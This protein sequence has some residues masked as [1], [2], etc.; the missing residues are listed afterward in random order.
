TNNIDTIIFNVMAVDTG[1]VS[2]S[3]RYAQADTGKTGLIEVDGQTLF[4]NFAYPKVYDEWDVWDRV[5]FNIYFSEGP[6]TIKLINNDQDPYGPRIDYLS[7]CN[8]N[9]VPEPVIAKGNNQFEQNFDNWVRLYNWGTGVSNISID[10]SFA[11]CGYKD[12][13]IGN[14]GGYQQLITTIDNLLIGDTVCLHF[15]AAGGMA[16]AWVGPSSS[17]VFEGTYHFVNVMW[18]QG[19]YVH[20]SIEFVATEPSMII[21]FDIFPNTELYLDNFSFDGYGCEPGPE[22]Y[23]TGISCYGETDASITVNCTGGAYPLSY[24][25]NTGDTVETILNLG[26]GQYTVSATDKNG[27][28]NSISYDIVEP[29]EIY[30]IS[31][32]SHETTVGAGDGEINVSVFGGISPYTYLWSTGDTVKNL[33]NV[34]GGF[35]T[36]SISDSHAC[37]LDSTFEV[38][39]VSLLPTPGWS[40]QITAVSHIFLFQPTAQLEID[41][42]PLTTGDYV[43]AF[44]D[45]LGTYA[46]AGYM[47]WLNSVNSVTVFGDDAFTSWPD[48]F[49]D[50][51][52]INWKVWRSSDSVL[53]NASATYVTNAPNIPD[54][55]YFAPNGLS[56]I[57]SMS[58]ACSTQTQSIVL[59]QGWDMYSSYLDIINPEISLVFDSILN[60]LILIKN[61]YGNVY[62]PAFNYN[63]I[64]DMITGQGYHINMLQTD[65][66]YISGNTIDPLQTTLSLPSGWSLVGYLHTTPANIVLML[67][68]IVSDLVIAKDGSGNVYWPLFNINTIGNMIPGK[69]YQLKLSASVSFSYPAITT[70]NSKTLLNRIEPVHFQKLKSG[71][72]N[73]TLGIPINTWQH[74]PKT[75]DEIGVFSQSGL[76]VGSSVFSGGNL[77][78]AIW[79]DD[80]Y[81]ENIAGLQKGEKFIL[82]IWHRDNGKEEIID[83]ENWSEGDDIYTAD[84]IAIVG[85]LFYSSVTGENIVLYQNMP[86]PFTNQT[87]FSFYLPA[88]T[89]VEFSI[90]NLL[91]EKIDLVFSGT[92]EAGLHR[93]KYQTKNLSAGSYYYHLKTTGFSSTKKMVV[94]KGGNK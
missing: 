82:K 16:N 37:L 52:A 92:K 33:L 20:D 10:S 45:S 63:G 43:G 61:T 42:V 69:G 62:W 59:Q 64:G 84:K 14:A 57:A 72:N 60:N 19:A 86:N 47:M 7:L 90:L 75:G 21:W 41:G 9:Y 22:L 91:G 23:V 27:I 31:T 38:S 28:S 51:D 25:W 87:E 93:I 35:Y 6:H 30:L 11:F 18:A 39:T 56:E 89:R 15:Y 54:S 24:L 73:M 5:Q 78:I 65:T 58:C 36:L 81:S 26:A 71:S 67:T 1:M 76:L 50:G 2:I 79:G 66:L 49:P 17:S 68:P 29:G 4:E 40:Y 48:G 3:I 77:A 32:I 13:Y 88:P 70:A 83:I 85:E 34:S 44:Y 53:L 8:P 46:C 12:A 74:K 55:G 94:L 80:I